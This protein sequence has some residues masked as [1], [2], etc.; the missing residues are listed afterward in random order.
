MEDNDSEAQQK[1]DELEYSTDSMQKDETEN[2][3]EKCQQRAEDTKVLGIKWDRMKDEFVFNLESIIAVSSEVPTK[4]DLLSTIASLFDPL[5]ILSPCTVKLK[6]LFQ[7]ATKDSKE[8]DAVLNEE[9]QK[10]WLKK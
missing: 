4:R 1:I 5:G 9:I 2:Q 10:E 7:K 3:L 8:W 6:M